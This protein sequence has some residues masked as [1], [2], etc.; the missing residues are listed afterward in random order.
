VRTQKGDKKIHKNS[1]EKLH[2]KSSYFEQQNIH[3]VQNPHRFSKVKTWKHKTFKKDHKE[4]LK[5][6]YY[7]KI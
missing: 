1:G 3:I 2:K 6:F 4:G 5:N 7:I